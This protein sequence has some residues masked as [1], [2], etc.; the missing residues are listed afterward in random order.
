MDTEKQ[1]QVINDKIKDAYFA[2]YYALKDVLKENGGSVECELMY[3][4]I[5]SDC[6]QDIYRVK[7]VYLNEY[8]EVCYISDEWNGED[9][10]ADVRF[11]YDDCFKDEGEGNLWLAGADTM[12]NLDFI[13]ELYH[14][15]VDYALPKIYAK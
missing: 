8:E 14:E 7:K 2:I 11:D 10:A 5:D 9:Y 6:E 12:F 4:Y 13:N 1:N 15:V 3:R